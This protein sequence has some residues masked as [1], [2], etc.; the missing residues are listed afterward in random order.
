M[1]EPLVLT[2]S[3][4]AAQIFTAIAARIIEETPQVDD[5]AGCSA[6]DEDVVVT[7]RRSQNPQA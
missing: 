4:T 5:M 7:V 6:R 2:S 3:S 1:G